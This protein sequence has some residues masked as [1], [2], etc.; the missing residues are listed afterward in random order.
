MLVP[1]RTDESK[2]A[3]VTERLTL[4]SLYRKVPSPSKVSNPREMDNGTDFAVQ[5]LDRRQNDT[6]AP[7]SIISNARLR[8]P[9]GENMFNESLAKRVCQAFSVT[10]LFLSSCVAANATPVFWTDWTGA[11]TGAVTG[12]FVGQGTITTPTSTVVVTYTNN[13]GI[14]FYQASGGTD[15]WTDSTHTVRDPA[16]SPFTSSSVDNIP[17]FT[18][19]VALQYA[20]SQTLSFSQT[21]ANPVF[22]YISLN[23]NGY[24]F[25]NQD[26]DILSFGDGLGA[27]AP[28]DNNCGW[29]GCGT[30]FKQVVDIGGGNTL[31]ELLGTGEPH[32]TIQFKGAFDTVSW[33]SLSDE[34][35]N[36]FTV[37]VQGTAAEVFPTDPTSVPEPATLVLFGAG[38]AGIRAMG[39]R[40]KSRAV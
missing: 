5:S 8:K 21:I 17:T 33:T 11:N 13:Q 35:W 3:P 2:T 4:L 31:Y 6:E 22:S 7:Q 36:G 1:L 34:Y 18:D 27:A 9:V 32:G 12:T 14:G 24:A 20:G 39:R 37:G 25:L 10:S 28:G 26:F 19:I 15:W 30:S 29:W 16:T 23:G 40:R 38:L